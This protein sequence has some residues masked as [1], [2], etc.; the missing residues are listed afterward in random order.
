MSLSTNESFVKHEVAAPI[1]ID[2][3]RHRL[4]ES[5]RWRIRPYEWEDEESVLAL[6]LRVNGKRL[7]AQEFHWKYELIPGG[8]AIRYVTED[9]STGEIV[10]FQGALPFTKWIQGRTEHTA[11]LVD[12]LVD[13]SHRKSGI[14]FRML[15]C[16]LDQIHSSGYRFTFG[17]PNQFALP[18]LTKRGNPVVATL[19][20]YVV[21]LDW[22]GILGKLIGNNLIS[23]TL[24][25]VG[26]LIKRGAPRSAKRNG[27]AIHELSFSDKRI[28]ELAR[29]SLIGIYTERNPTFLKWRYHLRPELSYTIIGVEAGDRLDA[30]AVISESEVEGWRIG[31]VM[32]IL[33]RPGSKAGEA[34]MSEIFCRFREKQ[35]AAA[36]SLANVPP[37]TGM[38]FRSTG[39]ISTDLRW[40]KRPFHLVFGLN[41][42]LQSQKQEA[43][44]EYFLTPAN[45]MATLGDT[46]LL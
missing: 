31:A 10:G 36:I 46:D 13:Q 32:D 38:L 18:N 12:T 40:T 45:W 1:R 20:F 33:V 35:L 43:T 2:G 7:S 21:P 27:Y 28:D 41:H 24:G 3:I 26:N 16:T 6:T 37:A 44:P 17:F 19:R 25:S 5:R 22:R 30:Y 34:L 4:R 29:A 39:F 9:K 8:P 14:Y 11:L 15:Q 42:Y 23:H